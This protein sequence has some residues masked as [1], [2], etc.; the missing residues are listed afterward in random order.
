MNRRFR[1]AA[2]ERLRDARL[3]EATRELARCRRALDGARAAR[4]DLAARLA[5]D[6]TPASAT[7]DRTALAGHHRA[8]L[9]DRLAAAEATVAEA[10]ADAAAALTA[11]Q[12]ARADVRVVRALHARHRARVAEADARREQQLTDELAARAVRRD[13]LTAGSAS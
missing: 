5:G 7:P 13:V 9:R 8:L 11:W 1:L 2:V 4:D 6:V 10:A 3:E 12:A